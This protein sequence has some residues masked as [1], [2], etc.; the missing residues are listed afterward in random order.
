MKKAVTV[1]PS[2]KKQLIVEESDGSLTVW[3]KSPPMDGKAN[4]ELVKLLAAWFGVANASITI[5]SGTA[6]KKKVVDIDDL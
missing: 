3:L 4:A 2:A 5:R 1:K 6:S